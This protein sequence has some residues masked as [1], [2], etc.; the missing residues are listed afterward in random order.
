MALRLAWRELRGGLSGFR[1]FLACLAL[2]VGAIAGVGAFRAAL[3]SGIQDNARALLGGEVE[4]RVVGRDLDAATRDALTARTA[5]MSRVQELRAMAFAPSGAR[6]LVELKGVDAGY[7]MYG[8]LRLEP[9]QS[10]DLL[11]ADGG[12]VVEP[13]LLTRLGVGLGDRLTIGATD[14]T[15][16]AL[17]HR[18][19]DRVANVVSLGPRLMIDRRSLAASGLVQEGSL[20]RH[21][22]RLALPPDEALEAWLARLAADFPTAHWQ[23][24]DIRNAQPALRRTVDRLAVFLTLVGM[25]TL[26]IGGIGVANAV[27]HH[28]ERKTTVIAVL[29]SLGAGSGLVFQSY[30]GQ[31]LMLAA[32]G[33]VLGLAIG[34][35]IPPIAIVLLGDKLPLAPLVLA[36]AAM[37]R[38]ALFGLLVALVFTLW[39][40]AKARET[41]AAGLFRA[42]VAPPEARPGAK[43]LAVLALLIVALSAL[44]IATSDRPSFAAWFVAGAMVTLSVLGALARVIGALARRVPRPSSAPWRLA[45]SSLARPGAPTASILVSLGSGLTA[46]VA[47][48]AIEANFSREIRDRV[49]DRAPTFF[50]IDIPPERA[51]EFDAAI[52]GHAHASDLNRQPMMRGRIVRVGERRIADLRVPPSSEWVTRGD[53]GLS[54][55]SDPLPGARLVSGAWW[56]KDYAGPPL[57]SLSGDVGRDLGLAVGDR[58]TIA[59]LGREIEARIANLRELDWTEFGI[60]FVAIFAPGTFE[61]APHVHIASVRVEAA[62]EEALFRSI[63]DRFSGVSIV[64]VREVIETVAENL[65]AI[66]WGVRVCAAIAILAGLLVLAGAVSAGHHRRVYDAVVLKTVGATRRDLTLALAL[67]FA[68][69]GALAGAVALLFGLIAAWAVVEW[70]LEISFVLPLAG[71]A[72][73]AATGIVLTLGL[74]LAATW[75]ILGRRPMSLLR[76]G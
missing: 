49:P 32:V 5:R 23:R 33:I 21:A 28:M 36:P 63:S 44:A 65:A 6:T 48:T 42:V 52:G 2:G 58:V 31:V 10:L 62:G 9:A 40:L 17:L 4:L 18:E 73:A 24:R 61:G 69:L 1:V 20:V 8:G 39:P 55:R 51:A 59:V 50:F 41:S 12:A 64:R 74:G 43:D 53:F 14:V 66:G 54:F 68:L 34:L 25:A 47:V 70:L 60:N 71:S 3:V 72:A 11:L 26:L 75:R 76:T 67:E 19:P 46:L 37:A 38:A 16:R 13:T 45:L 27:R 15:I 57:L 56:P 22:Y 7:P 29:K 35:F 30:L